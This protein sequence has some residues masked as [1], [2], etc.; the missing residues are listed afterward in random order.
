MKNCAIRLEFGYSGTIHKEK[1]MKWYKKQ[2]IMVI[3]ESMFNDGVGL[4]KGYSV[5][6]N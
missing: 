5:R 6:P 3:L 2:Q 4:S 1:V